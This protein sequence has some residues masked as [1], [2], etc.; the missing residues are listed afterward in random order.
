MLNF[1]FNTFLIIISF[2]FFLFIMADIEVNTM[3]PL[4]R[5]KLFKCNN[6]IWNPCPPEK[7]ICPEEPCELQKVCATSIHLKPHPD[8]YCY[9]DELIPIISDQRSV[10]L[11]LPCTDDSRF[12]IG[13][14]RNLSCIKSCRPRTQKDNIIT[15]EVFI[16]DTFRGTFKTPA[17]AFTKT[18]NCA[19]DIIVGSGRS[20]IVNFNGPI[21]DDQLLVRYQFVNPSLNN[22][23]P[24]TEEFFSIQRQNAINFMNFMGVITAEQF[25]LRDG[26]ST[27]TFSPLLE[28]PDAPRIQVAVSLN[29]NPPLA[30]YIPL[31]PVN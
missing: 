30:Y 15:D 9:K 22:A 31:T 1:F 14:C 19:P 17:I 28:G 25:V 29:G 24:T 13:R 11:S 10:L 20:L 26:D 8:E 23:P 7:P 18:N 2:T 4:K 3:I 16:F 21:T 6:D 12:I 27:I 5:G